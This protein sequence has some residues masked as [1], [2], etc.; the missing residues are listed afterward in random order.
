LYNLRAGFSKE[1]DSLP[2]R[3]LHTPLEEGGS[4][5]KVVHLH[6]MLAEY[7]RFR[8]WTTEGVPTEKKLKAI[9]LDSLAKEYS[10]A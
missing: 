2:H 5:N 7:Y 6:E 3:F 1:D 4:A 8:G 9:G 10:H